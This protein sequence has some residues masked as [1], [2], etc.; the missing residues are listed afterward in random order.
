MAE[1]RPF[2]ALYYNPSRI[3]QL[4][5]VVTQPYDK[6]S[7]EMQS[8]YYGSSPY[9]LVRV[10][11]GQVYAEDNPASNVYLR[12]SQKITRQESS[13]RMNRHCQG[14]RPTGWNC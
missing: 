13:F 8:R 9:N 11:R 4:E 2:R 14:P 1:I 3:Q 7:T 6:I 10:I 5:D 12:A